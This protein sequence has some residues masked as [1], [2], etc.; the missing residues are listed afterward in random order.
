MKYTEVALTI[1]QLLSPLLMA[2]LTWAAAKLADFIKRKVDNEYLRGVLVRLDEAVVT[3]VKD[4]ERTVVA[5]I[6]RARSNGKITEAEKRQI[7]EAAVANV[8]SYLGPKGIRVLGDVLGLSDGSLDSFL[9]AKVEAAVHDLRL[10][11][12][13]VSAVTPSNGV[14]ATSPLASSPA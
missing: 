9:G 14:K 3:T 2:A 11:E 4:F 7:K 8:K 12:R 5:E 10:S 6:K 1:V 13:A